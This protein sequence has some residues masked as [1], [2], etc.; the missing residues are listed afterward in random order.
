MR[1]ALLAMLVLAGCSPDIAPGSYLCGPEG[2]CPEG[3]KCNGPDNVCVLDTQAEPFSCD[4]DAD[5]TGDDAPATAQTIGE[6]DCVSPVH[7]AVGCMSAGDAADWY[8]FSVPATCSA[9]QVEVTL[10][11]PIAFEGLALHFATAG[12]AGAPVEMACPSSRSPDEG[13]AL[14]CFEMALTPGGSYAIG[15]VPDGTG[16]CDRTCAFN[17][18]RLRLQLAT[19]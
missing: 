12:G 14:R 10:A 17:R 18:Y 16:T 4:P 19:P 5:P 1:R 15:V 7:E 2:L 3:M 6:L 9:V 8:A 13:E 11:F